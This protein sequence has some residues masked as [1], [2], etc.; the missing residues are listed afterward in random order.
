MNITS[1]IQRVRKSVVRIYAFYPDGEISQGSGFIV[2]KRGL[3]LTNHHVVKSKQVA[4]VVSFDGKIDIGR[5]I[6]SDPYRNIAFI[7]GESSKLHPVELNYS[8]NIKVGEEIITIAHPGDLPYS[9]SKGI[10]SYPRRIWKGEPNLV[11]IQYDASSHHGS[12]G[13]P[14]LNLKGKVIGIVCQ[15]GF[16]GIETETLNLAIPIYTI[17]PSLDRILNKLDWIKKGKYCPICGENSD[18]EKRY[19]FKCGAKLITSSEFDEIQKVVKTII[20]NYVVCKHCSNMGVIGDEEN[21]ICGLC[22]KSLIP[23]R[24]GKT[25]KQKSGK[26]ICQICKANNRDDQQYCVNCGASLE[27]SRREA[28]AQT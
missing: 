15:G 19:C 20:K 3:I 2:D 22:G 11:H 9:V 10:I 5:V 28:Y 4:V 21:L 1:V 8:H 13:G 27:G 16:P 23:E 26:L 17:K 24:K 12:S 18:F 25:L 14:L 6:F 7:L